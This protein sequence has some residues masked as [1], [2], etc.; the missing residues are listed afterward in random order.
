MKYLIFISLTLY[1][2]YIFSFDGF[3]INK[4]DKL[5]KNLN[6]SSENIELIGR[7]FLKKD[8]KLVEEISL[9]KIHLYM[10]FLE[11]T[12]GSADSKRTLS[13]INNISKDPVVFEKA[14]NQILIKKEKGQRNSEILNHLSERCL[15][16][17]SS[18]RSKSIK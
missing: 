14:I 4:E 5:Y 12:V 9:A 6:L 10:G 11:M 8:D 13:I 3:C 18:T 7:Y 2:S 16:Y 15:K 1:S 17:L